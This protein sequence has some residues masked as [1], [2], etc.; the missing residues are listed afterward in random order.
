MLGKN[1]SATQKQRLLVSI[2]LATQDIQAVSPEGTTDSS[3]QAYEGASIA[4]S[5][6]YKFLGKVVS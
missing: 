4:K 5:G 6:W 3:G 2:S 1:I